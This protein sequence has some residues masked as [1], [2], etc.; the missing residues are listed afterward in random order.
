MSNLQIRGFFG[1]A[2]SESENRVFIW[3]N[4][5]HGELGNGGYISY[6]IP[7]EMKDLSLKRINKICCGV[8][9]AIAIIDDEPKRSSHH[10]PHRV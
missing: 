3:G 6:K 7:T 5:T 10:N 2:I 8:N 9:F 1:V 4:N